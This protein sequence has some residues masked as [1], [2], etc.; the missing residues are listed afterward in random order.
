MGAIF[1]SKE[2]PKE[3]GSKCKET[4]N[5][6]CK[7]YSWAV[8][9]VEEI[10]ALFNQ[11]PIWSRSAL[12]CHLSNELKR[13]RLNKILPYFAFYWLNGPWRALWNRYGFDPRQ[14]P[15]GKMYEFIYL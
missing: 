1:S 8:E 3:P 7:K 9:A 10:Q 13:E 11:R 4:V 15:E 6:L 14:K 2:V 5:D 12:V